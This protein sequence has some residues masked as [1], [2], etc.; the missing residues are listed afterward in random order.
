LGQFW[1]AVESGVF[2]KMRCEI[3]NILMSGYPVLTVFKQLS[4]DV[5]NSTKL[6]DTQKAKIFLRIAEADKKLADGASEH[7]QLMDITGFLMRTYH[8]Q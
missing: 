7:F 3:E 8:S 4:E 2:D 5:L 6:K 1:R